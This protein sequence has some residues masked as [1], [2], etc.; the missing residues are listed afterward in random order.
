MVVPMSMVDP[1]VIH[2]VLPVNSS[3]VVM[4][5]PV[6]EVGVEA[7]ESVPDVGSGSDRFSQRVLPVKIPEVVVLSIG[8][9]VVSD[10]PVPLGEPGSGVVPVSNGSILR[11]L[12]VNISELERRVLP[13]PGVGTV[14]VD[15]PIVG[16]EPASPDD[17]VPDSGWS[18]RLVRCDGYSPTIS[19]PT[20]PSGSSS[21]SSVEVNQR[22]GSRVPRVGFFVRLVGGIVVP[23]FGASVSIVGNV[24]PV[25]TR[26][27]VV[28]EELVEIV[29]RSTSESDSVLSVGA[30]VLNSD[31]LV[32]RSLV[33]LSI[34]L[35]VDAEEV[36]ER[37]TVLPEPAPVDASF[38]PGV[39]AD[40]SLSPSL[41]LAPLPDTVLL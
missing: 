12:P 8:R 25:M 24:D 31:S 5:E 13:C 3:N 37:S 7:E 14:A 36:P 4:V 32:L 9:T 26:R 15:N 35:G 28:L 11:V 38:D 39:V 33:L 20:C 6:P 29:V 2:R 27:V 34:V 23:A 30:E 18:V 21:E 19:R 17:V 10:D 41:V 16:M 22:P 1:L 40:G